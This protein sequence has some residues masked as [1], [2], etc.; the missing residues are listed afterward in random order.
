MHLE[1]FHGLSQLCNQFES[2]HCARHDLQFEI[3]VHW[4]GL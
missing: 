1:F 4:L 2:F 3:H